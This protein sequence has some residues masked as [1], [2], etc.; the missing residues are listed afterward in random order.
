MRMM[1]AYRERQLGYQAE[2]GAAA[3]KEYCKERE[4]WYVHGLPDCPF[5]I[6]EYSENGKFSMKCKLQDNW[7]RPMHWDVK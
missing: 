2:V 3:I 7:N 6:R 5:G 4:H 1:N